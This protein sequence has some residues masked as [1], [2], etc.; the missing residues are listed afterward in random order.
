MWKC[1]TCKTTE[2][3]SCHSGHSQ[4]SEA[5]DSATTIVHGVQRAELNGPRDDLDDNDTLASLLELLEALPAV[6]KYPPPLWTPR[7]VAMRSGMI[8]RDLLLDAVTQAGDSSRRG[9]VAQLLLKHVPWI[10]FRKDELPEGAAVQEPPSPQT[11]A[12]YVE[13]LNVRLQNA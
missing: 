8:L 7:R 3:P 11:V 12:K 5:C 2:C 6:A 13:Q 1:A 9:R 4:A 10:V